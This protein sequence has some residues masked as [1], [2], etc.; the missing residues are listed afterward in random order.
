[1]LIQYGDYDQYGERS[2]KVDSMLSKIGLVFPD[3]IQ[4]P[5]IDG[6]FISKEQLPLDIVEDTTLRGSLLGYPC[7]EEYDEI[8]VNKN[9]ENYIFNIDITLSDFGKAFAESRHKRVDD[10]FS[11]LTVMCK[12]IKSETEMNAIKEKAI[13]IINGHPYLKKI[14]KS[15]ELRVKRNVSVNSVFNKIKSGMSP[16][17]NDELRYLTDMVQNIQGLENF[18]IRNEDLDTP[19]KRGV[20]YSLFAKSITIPTGIFLHLDPDYRQTYIDAEEQYND[21]IMDILG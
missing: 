9:I 12:N 3:L 17:T 13:R 19:F 21:Y 6:V 11:L 1:M 18:F 7:Y 5:T 20:V 10:D 8:T 4:T 15:V 14:V 2:A 16:L